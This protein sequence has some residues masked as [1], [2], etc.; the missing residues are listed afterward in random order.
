MNEEQAKSFREEA[1]M[2]PCWLV[3]ENASDG[4]RPYLIAV[5]T[6][7]EQANRH[8]F[9]R[10]ETARIMNQ[11]PPMLH[12]DR[13][14][15]DHL[16]GESMTLSFDA[17]KKMVR[18]LQSTRIAELKTKLAHAVKLGRRAY[19]LSSLDDAQECLDEL[20]ALEKGT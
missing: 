7:E 5:D 20:A 17:A 10:K 19:M 4:G 6:S 9:S 11:P 16:Y 2:T 18:E 3:W 13:S 15:L 1:G 12:I 14:W 8:M